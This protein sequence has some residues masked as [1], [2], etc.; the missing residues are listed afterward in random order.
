MT[1]MTS[2]SETAHLSHS[3]RAYPLIRFCSTAANAMPL[4]IQVLIVVARLFVIAS[5]ISITNAPARY[6]PAIH[7]FP[8]MAAPIYAAMIESISSIPARL[9]CVSHSSRQCSASSPIIRFPL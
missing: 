2:S 4:P 9:L 1:A 3:F 8:A 7:F 5:A 6:S